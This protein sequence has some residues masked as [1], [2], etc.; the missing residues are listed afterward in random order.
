M[1][2]QTAPLPLSPKWLLFGAF[3]LAVPLAAMV[4]ARAPQPELP[5][6][7]ELPAFQL[8]DQLGN[9]FG[10]RAMA[11]KTW[12]A[13]FIFTSCSESCPLLTQR[14]KTL[15]D[16]L[17]PAEQGKIGLVSV[18]VDPERDTPQKLR[19]FSQTYGVNE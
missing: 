5:V 11:G 6:L 14:V 3:A 1:A 18:S 9:P 17:T 12:I 7:A 19:E 15:Q 2:E 8:T 13:N 10:T 4:M 16:K